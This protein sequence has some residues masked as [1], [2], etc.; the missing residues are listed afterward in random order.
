MKKATTKN[1]LLLHHTHKAALKRNKH[2]TL[3]L[4]N[5]QYIVSKVYIYIIA[6]F[7]VRQLNW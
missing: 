1:D 6:H 7:T 4:Y 3:F 5:I 2:W